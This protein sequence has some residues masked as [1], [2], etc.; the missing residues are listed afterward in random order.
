[1]VLN[2]IQTKTV[3]IISLIMLIAIIITVIFM[4]Y[5]QRNNLLESKERNLSDSIANLNSVLYN[6]MINGQAPIAVNT[7]KS[8]QSNGSFQEIVIYRGDGTIAFNDYEKVHKQC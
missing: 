2:S 3:T 7:L 5:N 1:M 6:I 4:V 8:Y